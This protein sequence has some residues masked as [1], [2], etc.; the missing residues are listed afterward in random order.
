MSFVRFLGEV[1]ARQ[2]CSEINW[3]LGKTKSHFWVHYYTWDFQ[4][5]DFDLGPSKHMWVAKNGKKLAGSIKG[6]PEK[7][8]AIS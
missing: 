2:F 3:P 7:L 6:H 5:E 1:T 4:K 8:D